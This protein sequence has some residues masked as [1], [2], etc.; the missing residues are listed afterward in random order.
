VCNE[1]KA[2]VVFVAPEKQTAHSMIA[3]FNRWTTQGPTGRRF[4]SE[5]EFVGFKS[6]WPVVLEAIDIG[7]VN[8]PL[9]E[10][11]NIR[12]LIADLTIR[13]TVPMFRAPK[14][15]EPNDGK[16]APAGYPVVIDIEALGTLEGALGSQR[17]TLTSTTLDD[18]GNIVQERS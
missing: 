17:G 1:Y 9:G 3:Q 15:G 10:Q 7:G 12:V 11:T 4:S 13:A 16:L 18:D 6:R 14:E 8:T 5:Y 2:Q